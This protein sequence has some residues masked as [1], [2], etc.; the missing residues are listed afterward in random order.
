MTSPIGSA[1]IGLQDQDAVYLRLGVISDH[2]PSRRYGLIAPLPGITQ[3]I[4]INAPI[5][6][7]K[8]VLGIEMDPVHDAPSALGRSERVGFD[9]WGLL[10]PGLAEDG[11]AAITR[12]WRRW[13]GRRESAR[14]T[15]FL[16]GAAITRPELNLAPVAVVPLIDVNTKLGIRGGADGLV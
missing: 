13:I 8:P 16:I 15:P 9:G 12:R 7:Q 10:L 6:I 5:P 3:Y 11:N 2:G 1:D 14:R 4:G